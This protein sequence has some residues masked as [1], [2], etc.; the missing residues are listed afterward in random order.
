[1]DPKAEALTKRKAL[2]KLELSG[3][4]KKQLENVASTLYNIDLHSSNVA[5]NSLTWNT[6]DGVLYKDAKNSYDAILDAFLADPKVYKLESTRAKVWE[7]NRIQRE[8]QLLLEQANATPKEETGKFKRPVP[9][10]SLEAPREQTVDQQLDTYLNP[11]AMTYI[12]P[13]AHLE[14]VNKRR[15]PIEVWSEKLNLLGV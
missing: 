10:K 6:T 11:F 5:Q 9:K 13:S 12:A 2:L 1:M 8:E 4:T 15:I 7:I 14:L 3:D